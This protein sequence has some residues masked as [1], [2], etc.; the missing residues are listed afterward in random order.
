[1]A[2]RV[3]DEVLD[4][5]LEH[6]GAERQFEGR[7]AL[8]PELDAGRVRPVGDLGRDALD[9]RQRPDR[10]E[11][12]HRAAALQLAEEEDVVDQ[13]ADPLHLAARTADQLGL[14]GA[15]QEGAF[16]QRKQ[17][18]ERRAEL[19]RDGRGEAGS[20]LL[21][22]REVAGRAQ[23]DERLVATSELVRDLQRR[24]P[25]EVEKLV[26]QHR[27]LDEPVERLT[28]PSAGGHNAP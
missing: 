8:D 23:I 6:P 24:A 25:A 10:A 1:M 20:E 15:G 7:R 9:Y 3:Q 22:R 12:D 13:L 19:V 21:V 26:G 16:E 2:N 4:H 18:G 27:S 28:G 11:R 14:V 17:P 5:D